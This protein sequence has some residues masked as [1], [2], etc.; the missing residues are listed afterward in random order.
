RD[1]F[2]VDRVAQ[3][4]DPRGVQTRERGSPPEAECLPEQ[5]RGLLVLLVPGGG[6]GPCGDVVEAVQIHCGRLDLKDVTTGSPDDVRP[7]YDGQSLPQ[8][9]EVAVEGVPDPLRRTVGPDAV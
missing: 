9:G 8:P 2:L 6:A 5:G 3:G 4:V 7:L 1:P